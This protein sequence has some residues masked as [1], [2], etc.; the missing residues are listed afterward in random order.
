MDVPSSPFAF[1]LET[2]P[3]TLL[4]RRTSRTWA[5]FRAESSL[6]PVSD[7]LQTGV[8]FFRP[9]KPAPPS[10]RLTARVPSRER[11]GVATFRFESTCGG[12]CLL[13]AGRR[14]GHETVSSNPPTCLHPSLSTA[15]ARSLTLGRYTDSD[16]FTVPTT[17]P[18]PGLRLPGGWLSSRTS[19][20]RA[21]ALRY[22]LRAALYSGAWVHPVTRVVLVL[23]R[24]ED[25]FMK[26]LRVAV[27]TW[28]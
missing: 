18:S 13:S 5:R 23:E 10:A 28:A 12:R 17:S 20:P 22:F 9:P 19:S 16:S 15:L 7:P 25:S 21:S 26:R 6:Q 1:P 27:T 3:Q 8:R 24:Y 2:V 14:H 4:P 11:Y